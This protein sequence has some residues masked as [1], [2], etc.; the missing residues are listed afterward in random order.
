MWDPPLHPQVLCKSQSQRQ[1][2]EEEAQFHQGPLDALFH[3]LVCVFLFIYIS[4]L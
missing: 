3:L 4:I 2:E 1:E